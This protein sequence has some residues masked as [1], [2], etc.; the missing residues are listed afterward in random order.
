LPR[1][2]Q[3]DKGLPAREKPRCLIDVLVRNKRV[4]LTET[5]NI[6]N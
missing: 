2:I 1:E 3:F 6:T 4:D 5:L